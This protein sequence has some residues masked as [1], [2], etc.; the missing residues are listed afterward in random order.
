[1]FEVGRKYLFRI[2]NSATKTG[3][4]Y[5]TGVISEITHSQ[6]KINTIK[7]EIVT[8]HEKTILGSKELED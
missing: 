6:L 1:M 5:Y 7:N 8:I 4:I 3:F 2:E